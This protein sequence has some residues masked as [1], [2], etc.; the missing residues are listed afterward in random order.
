MVSCCLP[1]WANNFSGFGALETA[2][3]STLNTRVALTLFL[4]QAI[5]SQTSEIL[6]FF[7][8]ISTFGRGDFFS[9]WVIFE[10]DQQEVRDTLCRLIFPICGSVCGGNFP[11]CY[12]I[13]T[14][15]KPLLVNPIS[16]CTFCATWI[17][18]LWQNPSGS[19]FRPS[20]SLQYIAFTMVLSIILFMATFGVL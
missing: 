20:R 10:G 15:R 9:R 12:F 16:V 8:H 6:S 7:A 17:T 19:A 1:L 13:C 14:T 4:P 3:L 2:G 5:F 18:Q 11:V